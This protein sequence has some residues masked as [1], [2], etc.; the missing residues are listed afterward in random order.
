FRGS[1]T[2]EALLAKPAG[3]RIAEEKPA[4]PAKFEGGRGFICLDK[5][6]VEPSPSQDQAVL[7]FEVA[8]LQSESA[9]PSIGK[10]RSVHAQ[11]GGR[12]GRILRNTTCCGSQGEVDYLA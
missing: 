7:F 1:G 3:L 10:K 12:K 6:R 4:H 9:I 5:S 11:Q 8:D 2:G